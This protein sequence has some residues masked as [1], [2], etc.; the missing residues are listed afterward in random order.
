MRAAT[1]A[2]ATAA[3]A[4][5]A[6]AAF[7]DFWNGAGTFAALKPA[8]R[9]A[10]A[11]QAARVAA[12]FVALEAERFPLSALHALAMPTLLLMGGASR[13]E[14]QRIVSL[15]FDTLPAATLGIVGTAGHMLP[16]THADTVNDRVAAHLDEIDG[17]GAPAVPATHR[18]A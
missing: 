12:N 1:A 15:M 3:T 13:P 14:T 5:D 16:I 6:M 17:R 7:I 9:D 4:T 2:D 8:V 18:A 10:L 11:L